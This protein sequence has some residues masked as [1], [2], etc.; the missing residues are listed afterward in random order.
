MTAKKLVFILSLFLTNTTFGVDRLIQA[1]TGN[2]ILDAATGSSVKIN[3]SLQCSVLTASQALFTDGSKKIVS[4]TITGTGNVVMSASPTLSGT[5]AGTPTFSSAITFTTAPI[6]SSTTASQALFTDASKNVVSNTITGTGNVVMSASPTL[7]GTIAG[8]PTFS[9]AI[10]FTTAPI[11]SSTTASKPLATDASKNI[12]TS[13]VTGTGSTVVLSASPSIS[14]PN[15]TTAAVSITNYTSGSGTYTVPAGV[16]WLRVRLIGGGGGGGGGQTGGGATIGGNGGNTTFG[17]STA[18]GGGGGCVST[19]IWNSPAGGLYTIGAG[20]SG[21]GLK[22][23]TGNVG[24]SNYQNAAGGGFGGGYGGDGTHAPLAGDTN[25]GGG[26]GNGYPGNNS[27]ASCGGGSG[28][29]ID[30]IITSP[31]V[32][33]AYSVGAAGTAGGGNTYPGAAGGS[34][35][36][37]IEEHYY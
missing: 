12:I 37:I 32:S 31:A 33:Y 36:I 15:I 34:G 1:P 26:G 16:K 24:T 2:L 4:N 8:T 22:G 10:T 23:M 7:S 29:F 25:S 9:S 18:N 17:A 30:G 11:L 6:L 19:A 20:M 35:V 28:G 27:F 21:L 14:S 3:K 5:I 13:P